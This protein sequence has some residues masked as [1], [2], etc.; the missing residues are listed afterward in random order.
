M[1]AFAAHIRR[2]IG[3]SRLRFAGICTA[4]VLVLCLLVCVLYGQPSARP[5]D[6]A[7]D[8]S[9]CTRIEI[10]LLPSTITY[11]QFN[12]KK[13]VLLTKEEDE[14]LRSLTTIVC[15][16]PENIRVF[17]LQD[18]ISGQYIGPTRGVPRIGQSMR[19]V[20]YDGSER[21]TSFTI[22]GNSLRTD[23]GHEFRYGSGFPHRHVVL[24]QV[25]PFLLRGV[26]ADNLSALHGSLTYSKAYERYGQWCDAVWRSRQESNPDPSYVKSPF[27]CPSAHVCHYAINP[28]CKPDSPAD[29]V[30]LFETKPGWNQHGGPELFTLDNHD[31]KGGCVLLKD[32]TVKFIR[33]EEELKQLRWK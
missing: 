12:N 26:C 21:A 11:L 25:W 18:L 9:R 2:E 5:P 1:V 10:S 27:E 24:S 23:D 7:Y 33:T 29:T 14:Y 15:D 16:N 17:A 3:Y 30:L 28:N 8:L 31:P 13:Q 19:I 6:P 4:L 20:G 22:I 32:G